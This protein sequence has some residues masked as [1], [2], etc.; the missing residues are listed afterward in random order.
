MGCDWRRDSRILV[1]NHPHVAAFRQVSAAG[2]NIAKIRE[3]A[4]P[5]PGLIL[6][7]AANDSFSIRIPAIKRLILDRTRYNIG[8]IKLMW[9]TLA[10]TPAKITYCVRF[11][12]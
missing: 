12:S 7:A 1:T 2:Q 3:P 4:H 5:H 8:S 6:F 11:L 10:L 9:L